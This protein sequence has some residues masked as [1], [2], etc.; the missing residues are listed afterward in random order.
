MTRP[1]AGW[2]AYHPGTCQV[3]RLVRRPG[4]PPRQMLKDEK[5]RSAQGLL[6][7]EEGHYLDKL[8]AGAPSS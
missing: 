2:A 1:K 8:L 7:K 4:E 5:W 3:S 6:A